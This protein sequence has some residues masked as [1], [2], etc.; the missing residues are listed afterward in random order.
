MRQEMKSKSVA[1]FLGFVVAG[2]LSV[3]IASQSGEESHPFSFSAELEAFN[4]FGFYNV[5][6]PTDSYGYI[7]GTLSGI[8]AHKFANDSTLK[9]ELGAAG[10][11]LAYDSTHRRVFE[12]AGLGYNYVGYYAGYR[13]DKA[14]S[15][16][17]THNYYIHNAHIAYDSERIS[18][19]VGRFAND[20][21]N[22]VVGLMEG[23]DIKA[24]LATFDKGSI[25]RRLEGIS[26]F[27]LLGDGFFWDFTQA[28]APDGLLGAQF[29]GDVALGE[30]GKFDINA[31]YYYGISEYSAPGLDMK[32]DFERL[33]EGDSSQKKGFSSH[34]RLNA[35]F[36]YYN[37]LQM[38]VAPLLGSF[39]LNPNVVAK[40]NFTSS[41]LARQDFRF[42]AGNKGEYLLGVAAY[43]NIGLSHARV[44]LYGS[45]LGVNIWDNSV[46]GAGPS[47]NGIVYKDALSAFVFTK[48]SYENLAR[49]LQVFEAG[50]D[51]R[52][53]TNTGS[54]KALE[55]YS[56]KLSLD[57]TL[58]KNIA[59]G[60]IGNYYT[61][62]VFDNNALNTDSSVGGGEVPR[63]K[64]IDRSYV[65]T[66]I[67]L[68]L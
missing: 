58:T 51:F 53:T 8:Y 22:Y 33:S 64:A 18:L 12:S 20:D 48:A 37:S 40:D 3:A 34:T 32:L 17:N 43:K 49:F 27:A 68:K 11:G 1:G 9:V 14:A 45:P 30:K 21:G 42:Y 52:Y 46:Y 19:K 67:S 4:K 41:I 6:S 35:I 7:L 31:F 65:M 13:G 55:E 5:V 63:G 38:R 36:P 59:F 2:G 39:L 23:A 66:R 24:T 26:A 57:F 16:T 62:V 44:G 61:S 54:T 15:A 29:G 28:Y 56:L 10:A 47:L 25:Y 60:V 50:L